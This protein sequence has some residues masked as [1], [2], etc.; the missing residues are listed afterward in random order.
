MPDN[1]KVAT[2][3]VSSRDVRR[4]AKELAEAAGLTVAEAQRV[5]EVMHV[6]KLVDNAKGLQ[7]LLSKEENVAALGLSQAHAQE[8]LAVASAEAL[9]LDNLRLGFNSA[10]ISSILV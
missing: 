8:R 9:T 10:S 4:I 1:K 7:K 5:L 6:D 3:R 2:T